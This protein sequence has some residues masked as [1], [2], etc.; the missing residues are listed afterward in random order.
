MGFTVGGR[1]I[2]IPHA[3]LPSTHGAIALVLAILA[4][5]AASAGPAPTSLPTLDRTLRFGS[6]WEGWQIMLVRTE[7]VK[8][9]AG[10]LVPGVVRVIVEVNY[11]AAPVPR[12]YIVARWMLGP[13]RGEPQDVIAL[14]ATARLLWVLDSREVLPRGNAGAYCQIIDPSES[15]DAALLKSLELISSYRRAKADAKRKA[16]LTILNSR[17][18]VAIAYLCDEWKTQG[19]K[20]SD[21]DKTL[22]LA[23]RDDEEVS[24]Y[25]RIEASRLVDRWDEV[26]KTEGRHLGWVRRWFAEPRQLDDETW[27]LLLENLFQFTPREGWSTYETTVWPM[28]RGAL[29][30]PT[31]N[32][33]EVR[34]ILLHHVSVVGGF[35]GLKP[36]TRH[37][38]VAF[39]LEQ[40]AHQPSKERAY[41]YR[42]TA[43]QVLVDI[44]MQI[45]RDAAELA[46]FKSHLGGYR[47]TLG[48]IL[49]QTK[50]ASERAQIRLLIDNISRWEK[51]LPTTMPGTVPSSTTPSSEA[52]K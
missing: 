29:L 21:E 26:Y 43:R 24:I 50:D 44:S 20:G 34:A 31:V 35:G 22:L 19:Y 12:E 46:A 37:A 48:A 18:T 16:A 51:S 33:V 49:S 28:I 27:R 25:A 2:M 47:D 52:M 42:D 38:V 14:P 39:L 13:C 1:E 36:E 8:S 23:V 40:S 5:G 32:D 41:W 9:D 4:G 30:A 6:F 15:A 3:K 10:G 11:S 7:S 45:R 17:H